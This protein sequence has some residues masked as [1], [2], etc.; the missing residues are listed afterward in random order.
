[1]SGLVGIYSKSILKSSNHDKLIEQMANEIT[2]RTSDKVEK[3][4]DRTIIMARVTHGVVNSEPQPIFNES[5]RLCIFME[6]EVFDYNKEKQYLIKKGHRFKYEN[7]DA[8]FCLN[9]YE[10]YG[11]NA[12]KK[13]NGSFILAIYNKESKELILVNDRFSSRRLFYYCDD[14]HLVFGSQLRPILK[15]KYFPRRLDFRSI[16]EFLAI[17]RVLGCRTFL[18]DAKVLPPASFLLFH[19][20]QLKIQKYWNL[21]YNIEDNSKEY[22]VDALT[23]ALIKATKRRTRGNDRLGIL[24]SGGL[25]S[26]MI[27]AADKENKISTAF[28]LADFEN[29]EVKVAEEVAKM[30][31]CKHLFLKRDL[32]HYVRIVDDA[33]DICDGMNRYD[34]AHFIG[35]QEDFLRNSDILFIGFGFNVMLR[36][37][38]IFDRIISIFRK[39]IGL[40]VPMIISQPY[41]KQDFFKR[42]P[43][44]TISQTPLDLF[45]SKQNINHRDILNEAADK[46]IVEIETRKGFKVLDYL[47]NR[48]FFE[49][50][51]YLNILCL[52]AY[53]DYRLIILDNDLL[54]LILSMPPTFRKGGLVYVESFKRLSPILS[55]IMDGGKNLPVDIPIWKGWLIKNSR[56]ALRNAGF[57]HE[58][59]MPHP[60]YTNKSWPK[61]EVL[62]NYNDKMRNLIWNTINDQECLN[63]EIFNIKRCKNIFYKHL[64][65]KENYYEMLFLLLTFGRWHK[66]YIAR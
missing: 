65:R 39:N 58:P 19:N 59:I 16:F 8:E 26:R 14:K 53:I 2:Y 3:W 5:N 17:Q 1:M 11:G 12:F 56:R 60:T 25:D 57:I 10:E 9:L 41:N 66:K 51:A 55:S 31:G 40:P 64:N 62:M 63:P 38:F 20:G 48:P 61:R 33:V 42:I 35:F 6:G 47:S 13:F 18:H 37:E 24:L 49:Y 32:D 28:T 36:G 54:E 4:N 45:N 27:L 30:K 50:G 21:D 52:Q 15:F 7:N 46:L 29:R 44:D 43:I 23:E 34:H 22:F